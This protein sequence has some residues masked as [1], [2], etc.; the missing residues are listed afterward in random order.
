MA[1]NAQTKE[2]IL[3]ILLIVFGIL[4]IAVPN[5]LELLVGAAFIILG[6]VHFIPEGSSK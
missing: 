4:V 1:N 5:V 3:G 2:Y 6:L